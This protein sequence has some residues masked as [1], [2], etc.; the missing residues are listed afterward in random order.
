MPSL[1]EFRHT[2]LGTITSPLFQWADDFPFLP[3]RWDMIPR[4]LGGIISSM[5]VSG[6]LKRW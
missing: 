4:S 6:S 3:I 5:V 1:G 2:L